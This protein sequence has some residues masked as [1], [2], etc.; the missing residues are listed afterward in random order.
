MDPYEASKEIAQPDRSLADWVKIGLVEYIHEKTNRGITPTDDDLLL[1]ARM[2]IRKAEE[3]SKS[4]VPAV[5]WFRD[6][7]MLSG[8]YPELMERQIQE[9]LSWA[10]KL[11]KISSQAAQ[12][13]DLDVISCVKQ[14]ALKAFVNGKQAL[15]LTP[16]NLELQ[17]EA[18]HILDNLESQSTYPCEPALKWFKYL[19]NASTGWLEEFRRRVG[20]PR[21]AELAFETIR[22]TDDKSMDYSIHNLGRLEHELVNYVNIQRAAGIVPT[23]AD[24]QRQA[25]LIIYQT[26]DPWNQT[27]ADVPA[28]LLVFKR[29]H[30]LATSAGGDSATLNGVQSDSLSLSH[31]S[32]SPRALHWE[33]ETGSPALLTPQSAGGSG[34]ESQKHDQA[35]DSP[36]S[37]QP[38]TN[39]HR[40]PLKY[41]L[42]DA[43][44]YGRLVRELSR[45]VK[46]CMSQNNPNQHVSLC[47]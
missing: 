34:S 23:D 45:F 25:R 2:I 16:T 36:A 5:S 14:R 20:I 4:Q 26:D 21:S 41:F 17:V 33:L 13:N 10:K 27:A 31:S 7:I 42:N 24:L 39:S 29:D 37:N 35:L 30:G 38:P 6:L 28:L 18:C 3:R 22:S 12:G 11:E 32:S 8:N 15:G 46:N 9:E 40:Q 47:G 44:C 19:I 1:E 43:Q